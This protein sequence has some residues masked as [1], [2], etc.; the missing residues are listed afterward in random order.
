[1]AALKPGATGGAA[2]PPPLPPNLLNAIPWNGVDVALGAGAPNPDPVGGG[3]PK[4][5]A[6]LLGV[7]APLCGTGESWPAALAPAPKVKPVDTGGTD[8]A[9]A[10]PSAGFCP[11]VKPELGVE[12][13]GAGAAAA[14]EPKVKSPPPVEGVPEAAGVVDAAGVGVAAAGVEV[15]S[16]LPLPKVNK[17][18]GVGDDAGLLSLGMLAPN[19]KPLLDD[20]AGAGAAALS[21]FS[22]ALEPPKTKLGAAEPPAGVAAGFGASA[23]LA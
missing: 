19:V 23:V 15:A 11:K 1:M 22:G 3:L 21:S 10:F 17:P 2:A 13:A 7:I 14:P 6:S 9:G 4:A 12:L 8:A 20:G 16:A 5:G 18:P